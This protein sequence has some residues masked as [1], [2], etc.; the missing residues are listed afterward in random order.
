MLKNSLKALF[1]VVLLL[2]VMWHVSDVYAVTYNRHLQST[3]DSLPSGD[4]GEL[5]PDVYTTQPLPQ[6]PVNGVD[7][8]IMAV[9]S[10]PVRTPAPSQPASIL[11][12]SSQYVEFLQDTLP[13]IPPWDSLLSFCVPWDS[14]MI[15]NDTLIISRIFAARDIYGGH[16]LKSSDELAPE[17]I[18]IP[19]RVS[20]LLTFIF[21]LSLIQIGLANYLF[22]QRMREMLRA[23]WDS[24][25]YS[26]LERGSGILKHYVSYF[27]FFNF[28]LVTM[29]LIYQSVDYFGVREHFDQ[30]SSF[31]FS[32]IL[33]LALILYYFFKYIFLA[34]LSWVFEAKESNRA[35]FVNILAV[36]NFAGLVLLPAMIINT[37]NPT[38]VVLYLSIAVFIIITIYKIARG[39]L[40]GHIKTGLPK[41]YLILYICTVEIAPLLLLLKIS[42]DY[43]SG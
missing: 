15:K 33:L 39:A 9:E 27:L 25:L 13:Q 10:V 21:I 8:T 11:E 16:L 28:L 42:S 30:I 43:L 40:F 35:Y 31:V 41:Y 5:L 26:Q 12:L 32:G 7:D 4:T 14:I 22:P 36:N 17:I 2:Q 37:Y 3:T 38:S 23:A 6:P 20:A 19:E 29:A 24:R 18:Q 34:F 1:W